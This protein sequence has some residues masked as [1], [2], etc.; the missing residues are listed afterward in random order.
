[1]PEN[2]VRALTRDAYP[3][4]DLSLPRSQAITTLVTAY[5]DR[6]GPATIRDAT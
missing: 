3:A 1:M 4:L 2:A 5:F 6:Y